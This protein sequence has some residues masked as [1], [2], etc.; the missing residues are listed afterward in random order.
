MDDTSTDI[1]KLKLRGCIV[2]LASNAYMS[3]DQIL[4]LSQP[5]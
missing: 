3:S 5:H 2:A 1:V 4:L